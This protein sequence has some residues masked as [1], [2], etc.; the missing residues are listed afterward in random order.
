MLE[1]KGLIT[2]R[3]M[4][5]QNIIA[6]I[7]VKQTFVKPYE[8]IPFQNIVAQTTDRYEKVGRSNQLFK[9]K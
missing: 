3:G 9:R 8:S 4:Y 2:N 5:N 6:C 1:E 7:G